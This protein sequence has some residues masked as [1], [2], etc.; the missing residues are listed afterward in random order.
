[1]GSTKVALKG[2]HKSKHKR[3]YCHEMSKKDLE[4]SILALIAFLSLVAMRLTIGMAKGFK[5]IIAVYDILW[6]PLL[7]LT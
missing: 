1:M 6:M 3:Y 4:V 5:N 2:M 7:R